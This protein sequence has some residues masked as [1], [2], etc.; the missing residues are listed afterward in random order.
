MKVILLKH[1]SKLILDVV[2]CADDYYE[3]S[4]P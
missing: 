4:C 2:K 1:L 3:P